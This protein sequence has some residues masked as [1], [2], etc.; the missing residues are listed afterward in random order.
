MEQ[1][2]DICIVGAGIIGMATAYFL[3]DSKLKICVIDECSDVAM[4]TS[5]VNGGQLNPTRANHLNAYMTPDRVPL[6]KMIRV[7]ALYPRWT[8]NYLHYRY[9]L[10]KYPSMGNIMSF[11]IK[12]AAI[13]TLFYIKEMKWD[14]LQI[15]KRATVKNMVNPLKSNVPVILDDYLVGA[16]SSREL[17]HLFKQKCKNIDFLFNHR[18]LSFKHKKGHVREIVTNKKT[19]RADKY[20]L[21]MGTGL[22]KWFPIMPVY[23]L[24]REYNYPHKN[25][26]HEKDVILASISSRHAYMNIIGN[27]LR[28]GGEALIFRSKPELNAFNLPHWKYHTPISQWIGARP[29]SPDGMPIIGA[30]PGY[31]NVYVNGGHGFWG[32]TLSLGTAKILTQHILHKKPIPQVFSP[33]RFFF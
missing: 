18:V 33:S 14:G 10:L 17:S 29:V 9:K 11:N 8:A 13:D 31:R 24:I 30:L 20:I 2:Y 32:W 19:I 23:G 15:G 6:W 25:L 28:I 4:V 5:K 26:F 1:K 27:K 16:G 12:K 3:K 22:S 21:T 7:C